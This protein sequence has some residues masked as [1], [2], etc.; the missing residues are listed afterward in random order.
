[1]TAI[2]LVRKYWKWAAAVIG[3]LAVVADLLLRSP[4]Q[5]YLRGRAR[6]RIFV[7]SPE[8]YTRERLVNDRSEED[9]WLRKQLQ[10]LDEQEIGVSKVQSRRER[11][12]LTLSGSVGADTTPTVPSSSAPP[13]P[14]GSAQRPTETPLDLFYERAASRDELRAAL[15]ENQLDDRHDLNGNTLYRLN[16]DIA[17]VP[18]R[19]T[20]PT[21][22][23]RS[24]SLG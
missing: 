22:W 13:A 15:I 9:D 17:T 7:G 16:F 19:G 23:W 10:V 4:A 21:R 2:E 6:G 8:V 11:K 14:A 3:G 24:E 20:T 18:S 12:D 5:A 1:M